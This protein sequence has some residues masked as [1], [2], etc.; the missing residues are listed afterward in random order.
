MRQGGFPCRVVGCTAV[1]HVADAKTMSSLLIASAERTAHEETVHGYA[2][3]RL[4][5][6]PRRT[7]FSQRPKRQS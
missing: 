4:P 6:A 3:Q 2:H 5:D 7:S 1:W